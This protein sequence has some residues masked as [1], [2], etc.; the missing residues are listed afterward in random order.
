LDIGY[1]CSQNTYDIATL[2][3]DRN[4]FSTQNGK[5][6]SLP[7]LKNYQQKIGSKLTINSYINRDLEIENIAAQIK[8]LNDQGVKYSDMAILY[9]KNKESLRIQEILSANNIPIEVD[10]DD[11]ILENL[12]VEQFIKLLTLVVNLDQPYKANQLFYEVIQ[13]EWLKIPNLSTLKLVKLVNEN[14][15][16]LLDLFYDEDK[17]QILT[18][19]NNLNIAEF[20]P[21]QK[22][23]KLLLNWKQLDINQRLHQTILTIFNDCKLLNFINE[24]EDRF[25]ILSCF[26][27]FINHVRDLE[28]RNRDTKLADLIKT[29]TTMEHH[30]LK[31][32][33]HNFNIRDN[34]VHLSTVHK[35]KGCEWSHVFVTGVIDGNWGNERE[36]AKIKLPENI[37][38]FEQKGEAQNEETKRLLYVA[39]TRAKQEIILSYP[40][41]IVEE[42][43]TS[44][45]LPSQFLVSIGKHNELVEV[46]QIES[47]QEQIVK[48]MT[49]ALL[50]KNFIDSNED[51]KAY[52]KILIE[53]FVLSPSSLNDY[54]FDKQ[55]FI[56]NYLLRAP[57]IN[58]NEANLNF[59]VAFHSAL[60]K[61][62][63]PKLHNDSPPNLEQIS[64]IFTTE[65]EK[66]YLDDD[67]F[68]YFNKVG[69]K[70][71]AHFYEQQVNKETKIISL[72]KNF[73][74]SYPI[75]VDGVKIK[76]KVDRIDLI[77]NNEAVII[78]YKTGTPKTDSEICKLDKKASECEK[79]LDECLWGRSKRQLLFY[80]I[81]SEVDPK[82]K[83]NATHGMLYFVVGDDHKKPVQRK[84]AF[85]TD[86]IEA[87]KKLIKKVD[88]EIR[89]LKFLKND[90]EGY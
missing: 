25:F 47:E 17:L 71:L 67:D 51:E 23:W 16:K 57:Q 89:E 18:K 41:T 90:V 85:N 27:T 36:R 69:L 12:K 60:Q 48:T 66:K 79:Q 6:I 64:Q 86:E 84:I 53:D 65:L 43:N 56:N 55:S 81:L 87:M 76:G 33:V 31:I 3:I 77:E 73:G 78:D 54:L 72:E 59:G 39:I 61:L 70:Y 42:N 5:K 82:F 37:L 20:E 83:H 74:S 26:Y 30:G 45:K 10:S 4:E 44:Q 2:L 38:K 50:P 28:K 49:D 21:L 63:L 34:A 40:E 13:Y 62:M 46:N 80:K 9:K 29:L 19:E 1:R 75:V 14:K 35:A 58:K 32:N 88:C 15:L 68:Y 8:K 52:F 7:K 11:N 24:N 22:L